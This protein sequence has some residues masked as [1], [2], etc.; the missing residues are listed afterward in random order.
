VLSAPQEDKSLGRCTA[1][2]TAGRPAFLSGGSMYRAIRAQATQATPPKRLA[3]AS[4]A[5][6]RL[7]QVSCPRHHEADGMSRRRDSCVFTP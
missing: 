7:A 3:F 2:V 6:P 4:W 1:R 5:D